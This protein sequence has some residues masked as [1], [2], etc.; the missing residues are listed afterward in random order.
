MS[1]YLCF[2]EMEQHVYVCIEGIM[3][4]NMVLKQIKPKN[5]INMASQWGVCVVF[6]NSHDLDDTWTIQVIK[7]NSN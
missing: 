3:E 5:Q 4:C 2:A 1:M 6:E 7:L